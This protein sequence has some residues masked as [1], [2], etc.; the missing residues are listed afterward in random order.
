MIY[1]IRIITS[2]YRTYLEVTQKYYYLLRLE[3]TVKAC[4]RTVM[5]RYL[6]LDNPTVRKAL[7]TLLQEEKYIPRYEQ[8]SW[9]TDYHFFSEGYSTIED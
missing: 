5:G 9:P 6:I 1:D 7:E 4:Y 2:L 3:T 8:V